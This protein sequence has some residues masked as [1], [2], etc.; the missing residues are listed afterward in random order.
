MST[1]RNLTITYDTLTIGGSNS[2]VEIVDFIKQGDGFENA[3]VEFEFVR[4]ASTDSDSAWASTLA[5][6]RNTFRTP[7]KNLTILQGGETLLSLKQTDNTGFDAYPTI[8]KDGS[9]WDTG[10]SRRFRIRIEFGLP[11]DRTSTGFRR[12]STV[13]VEFAPSRRRTVQIN[14]TYTANSTDG[15]TGS[16]AQYLAEIT[17]YAVTVT[18]GIDSSADWE[19]IAET[20]TRGETD[21]ITDFVQVYREIIFNQK[22]GTLDDADIVD[23]QL[24]ITREKEAP[25]DSDP[26]KVGV[27]GTTSPGAPGGT[28]AAQPPGASGGGGGE[29][30]ATRP[31]FLNVSYACSIDKTATTDLKSKWDNTI[32]PFLIAQ[33]KTFAG[34]GVILLE[35]KPNFGD[36]YDN[37]MSATMRLMAINATV[38]RR[39]LTADDSVTVGKVL[40]P[41]WDGD[42]YSFYKF[43]G[44]RVRIRTITEEREEQTTQSDANAIVDGLLADSGSASGLAGGT[45]WE[46]IARRPKAFSLKTGLSGADQVY[47][48]TIT[49]ETT[50]QYGK[51]RSPS[52]AN[53]GG[54][55]GSTVTGR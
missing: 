16:Y 47:I 28:V 14:G 40:V 39:R 37:R 8:T 4:Q 55:T 13:G 46:L 23:P 12:W 43:Q 34:K 33:A 48:A 18:D 26:S 38:L 32:R 31:T 36:L 3:W 44:P 50:F 49:I 21:K 24:V 35:E 5:S 7:R 27:T 22:S 25:G 30:T 6:I 54:I 51:W 2:L 15:T 10:R 42:P 41:V 9:E 1:L 53:A 52:I 29:G 20:I 45:A 19:K 11:A 17:A